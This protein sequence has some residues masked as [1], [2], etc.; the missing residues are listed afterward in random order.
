MDNIYLLDRYEQIYDMARHGI[1]EHVKSLKV[2]STLHHDYVT[3]MRI[4]VEMHNGKKFTV[5]TSGH[6][7]LGDIVNS[8]VRLA[9]ERVD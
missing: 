3:P 5:N 2:T 6:D 1:P 7:K 9:N 8:I 4:N